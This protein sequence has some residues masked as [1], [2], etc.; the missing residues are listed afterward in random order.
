MRHLIFAVA[1]LTGLISSANGKSIDGNRLLELCTSPNFSDACFGYLAAVADTMTFED[2]SGYSACVPEGV[3]RGQSR[4]IVVRYLKDHAEIRHY[5]APY[6]IS[7]AK[8]EA[9]PCPKKK[10]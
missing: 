3:T 7:K 6:L 5:I 8:A 10:P 9:F 1:L 4:D 2:I